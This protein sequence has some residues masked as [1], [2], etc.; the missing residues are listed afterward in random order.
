MKLNTVK[1]NPRGFTLL[2]LL[3]VISIIAMLS[4]F[5]LASISSARLKAR[6]V[7]RVTDLREIQKALHLY[8]SDNFT[9]PASASTCNAAKD[10]PAA[11][12]T[13]LAPYLSPLPVDPKNN[14]TICT[15]PY[16]HYYGFSN[17]MTWVWNSTCSSANVPPTIILYGLGEPTSKK[18]A[19]DCRFGSGSIINTMVFTK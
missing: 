3:V 8:Y 10:W 11:F 4:S 12:K 17:P 6:D 1:D 15:N 2:E 13:A 14:L 19:D 7:R 5:I 18:Y 9:Y 16:N